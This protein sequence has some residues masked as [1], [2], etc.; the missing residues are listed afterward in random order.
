[1]RAFGTKSFTKQNSGAVEHQHRSTKA[2][3]EKNDE[4]YMDHTK[5]LGLDENIVLTHYQNC[6]LGLFHIDSTFRMACLKL[7]EN[8]EAYQELL[9]MR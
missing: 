3:E 5:D 9:F 1:M 6:S 2:G 8:K 7:T 4:D